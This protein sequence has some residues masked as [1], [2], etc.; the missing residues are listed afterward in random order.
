[1]MRMLFLRN[2]SATWEKVYIL[3]PKKD[4]PLYNVITPNVAVEWVASLCHIWE[5]LVQIVAWTAVVLT[6]MFHFAPYLY[7]DAGI[8]PQIRPQPLPF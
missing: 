8:A 4:Y 5:V 2:A 6:D 1:M 3:I 7:S